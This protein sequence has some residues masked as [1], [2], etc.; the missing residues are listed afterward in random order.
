[1]VTIGGVQLVCGDINGDRQIDFAINVIS[2][3]ALTAADF[4][5]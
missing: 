5:L 4:V 3:H 2:D 1:M